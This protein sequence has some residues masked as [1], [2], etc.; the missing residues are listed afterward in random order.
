MIQGPTTGVITPKIESIQ[1]HGK[2]TDKAEK[3]SVV[4]IKIAAHARPN[5]KVFIIE[6]S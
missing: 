4:G 3:R 2:N 1:I 5:D 6:D